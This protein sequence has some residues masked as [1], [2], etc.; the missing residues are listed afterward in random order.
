MLPEFLTAVTGRTYT[1]DDLLSVGG[2][3]AN[4]RQAFNCINDL[5][6]VDYDT[7]VPSS[8]SEA[9]QPPLASPLVEDLG[10]AAPGG[11]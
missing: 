7:R 9:T 5:R 1:L 4:I 8:C 11:T 3:I 10:Q 6:R 2:R